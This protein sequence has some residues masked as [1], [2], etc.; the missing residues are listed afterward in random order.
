MAELSINPLNQSISLLENYDSKVADEIRAAEDKVDVY[1]DA[2]GSYLVKLASRSMSEEDSA[3]ITKLLHMIGDLERISD[4]SVN[5][6]E[7]AEEIKDKN[8]TFSDQ[9][10]RELEAMYGAVRE[11]SELTADAFVNT[12]MESA[13]KV[14][15]LEEVVDDL[16]DQIRINHII[17]VQKNQCTIELG[18]ILSDIL[19]NLERVSDH[20]SNIAG[21]LIEISRHHDALDLHNY[22]HE[23]KEAEE[24]HFNEQ[25]KM[26]SDK[27]SINS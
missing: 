5:L 1:E 16:K 23:L 8:V 15:P 9:A 4:H 21:C 19:T 12:N 7:S 26:Y 27:Y 14:E 2:L 6:V 18:F 17:R 3:E 11:I 13:L 24:T 10:V 25:Y 22:M 20:C